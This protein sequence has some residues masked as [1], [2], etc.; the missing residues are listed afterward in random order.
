MFDIERDNF[1]ILRNPC[2][3]EIRKKAKL[4]KNAQ[5]RFNLKFVILV[6]YC[7]LLRR[8]AKLQLTC[9]VLCYFAQMLPANEKL[10]Q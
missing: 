7:L 6:C 4:C 10:P 5:L 3:A 8:V 1:H 2:C 9:W